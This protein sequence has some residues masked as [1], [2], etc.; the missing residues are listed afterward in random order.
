MT[1]NM[2]RSVAERCTQHGLAQPKTSTH[3]APLNQAVVG[4][5][6]QCVRKLHTPDIN[7]GRSEHP[8]SVLQSE[9]ADLSVKFQVWPPATM[10]STGP[11][12]ALL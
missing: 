7:L 4:L 11:R 2:H 12:P 5:E 9:L 3:Q 6:R 10:H 8:W 1:H